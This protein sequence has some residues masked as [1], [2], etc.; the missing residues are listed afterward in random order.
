MMQEKLNVNKEKPNLFGYV[1]LVTVDN[2]KKKNFHTQRK[3]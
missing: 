1:K 3:A 2:A